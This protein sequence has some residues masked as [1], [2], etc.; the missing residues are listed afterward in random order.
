MTKFSAPQSGRKTVTVEMLERQHI[1]EMSTKNSTIPISGIYGARVNLEQYPYFRDKLVPTN[2]I[3]TFRA[4]GGV[5]KPKQK[6]L[7]LKGPLKMV[8]RL[9]ALHYYKL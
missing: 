4:Y 2:F 9:T 1:T 7:S 5:V 6:K 3:D 8:L